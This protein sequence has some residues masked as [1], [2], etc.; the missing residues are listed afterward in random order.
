MSKLDE[1]MLSLSI[2]VPKRTNGFVYVSVEVECPESFS[3]KRAVA[4]VWNTDSTLD[5]V[6]DM[7]NLYN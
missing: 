3:Y 2:E 7:V 1:K 6:V 5:V 4:T